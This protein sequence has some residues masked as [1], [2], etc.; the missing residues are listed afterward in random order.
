MSSRD[1]TLHNPLPPSLTNKH[2]VT[3]I[4]KYSIA[5][6]GQILPEGRQGPRR[7]SEAGLAGGCYCHLLP[8]G[9]G[10]GQYAKV[11]PAPA[12]APLLV[13]VPAPAPA[14]VP[15]PVPAPAPAPALVPSPSSSRGSNNYILRKA[16]FP[17]IL[18]FLKNFQ[19]FFEVL[20]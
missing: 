20:F 5:G 18:E 6:G 14:L 10:L 12:P 9:A 19:T 15:V 3:A 7:S 13:P 17:D 1:K 8:Q 2:S 4:I 16:P 11:T